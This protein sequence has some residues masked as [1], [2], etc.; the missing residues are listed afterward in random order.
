MLRK[1]DFKGFKSLADVNL[2]LTPL[3]VLVGPN[4]AGK[5]S[6]LQALHA[7]GECAHRD[8]R[9]TLTP[10]RRA[11]EVFS[12][13]RAP[14]LVATS[15][16][17]S[18][19]VPHVSI[20]VTGLDESCLTVSADL[21]PKQTPTFAVDPKFLEGQT[22]WA[23]DVNLRP[24][25]T[26]VVQSVLL[27]LD[28]GKAVQPST[29][30]EEI[31]QVGTDGSNLASVLGYLAGAHADAL[32]AI[33]A[34]L[35]HIVARA[36][37]IRIHPHKMKLNRKLLF[38]DTRTKVR[39]ETVLQDVV[40]QRFSID[41]DGQGEVVADHLS[42][43]TVLALALLT[44][45][46]HPRV[47]PRLVLMDDLDNA[48]HLEAQHQLVTCIRQLQQQR[49]DLQVIATTHSPYLLDSLGADEVQVLALDKAGHTVAKRLA[50]HPEWIDKWKERLRTGEFW[51]SFGEDWVL[52]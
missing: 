15:I 2:E 36:G 21:G 43:G 16:P 28:A 34:D 37:K 39:E 6:I 27:R 5:T 26:R 4:S 9:G 46:H 35:R 38:K 1:A 29:T 40:G 11:A 48:L 12:G 25:A 51:A 19:K 24:D 41:M 50:D 17:G 49:S 13:S 44:V 14:D 30:D 22:P 7:L 47:Q 3:T 18:G 32:K 8:P 31:P 33:E 23:T 20:S 10:F 52:S 45:L 42:E